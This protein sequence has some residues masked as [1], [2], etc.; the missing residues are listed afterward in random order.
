L[1]R[2]A[3][4]AVGILVTGLAS[5][6]GLSVPATLSAGTPPSWGPLVWSVDDLG[7]P[8]ELRDVAIGDGRIIAVGYSHWE[9]PAVSAVL[10]SDDRGQT[11]EQAAEDGLDAGS[12][13]AV[14]HGP[15]G[16]VAVGRPSGR[17]PGLAAPIWWSEDGRVW[18]PVDPPS[19][20]GVDLS[21][22]IASDD[23]YVAGG[24]VGVAPAVFVS[25]DGTSWQ[26]SAPFYG[27]DEYPSDQDLIGDAVNAL[28]TRDGRFV[29]ALGVGAHRGEI[30]ASDNGL[31]WAL[32][33]RVVP[34]YQV[35]RMIWTESGLLA[36]GS[37]LTSHGETGLIW[38][39]T[40]GVAWTVVAQLGLGSG[41]GL[42]QG[43]GGFVASS[44]GQHL[45]P[46][47]W[48]SADGERWVRDEA[49]T[50]GVTGAF[51]G[52]LIGLGDGY[53]GVGG[54]GETV[55]DSTMVVWRGAPAP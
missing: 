8:A 11:W 25:V 4:V 34:S 37:D 23:R 33:G 17:G 22:V 28:A 10:V 16:F 31:A 53:V 44:I 38:A 5:A 29:A 24:M 55:D 46:G 45:E 50:Q 18:R 15:A 9:E 30:W 2:V 6:C 48:T 35:R 41:A 3:F 40:D 42:T 49:A 26:A 19:L 14:T 27:P 36:V 43:P 32:I 47:I 20:D 13:V 21:T 1:H 7:M 52:N 12:M 51:A 54:R 39:S